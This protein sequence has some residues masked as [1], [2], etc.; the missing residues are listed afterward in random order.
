[1]GATLFPIRSFDIKWITLHQMNHFTKKGLSPM[2][3]R[4]VGNKGRGPL[5][6]SLNSIEHLKPKFFLI[7]VSFLFQVPRLV[8]DKRRGPAWGPLGIWCVHLTSNQSFDLE[9]FPFRL[10]A[11]FIWMQHSIHWDSMYNEFECNADSNCMR[12]SFRL[13]AIQFSFACNSDFILHAVQISF[14]MQCRFLLHAL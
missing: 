6:G 3:A 11:S 9:W 12:C 13:H 5:W 7:T 4:L 14:R 1:M 8:G 10:S 2:V